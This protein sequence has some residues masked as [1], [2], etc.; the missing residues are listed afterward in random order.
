MKIVNI[1]T[2][3]IVP[4]ENNPRKNDKAVKKVKKSIEEF[5]FKVPVILDKNNVIVT[6]H[7]R[8]KAAKELNLKEVP[9]V[10]AN[11]LTDEQIKAFRIA[12]N[13]VSE[14]AE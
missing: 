11:D 7:T 1:S 3:K 10:Y 6:G 14:D 12:D 13:R 4:Y 2:S 5:G 9:C 8:L